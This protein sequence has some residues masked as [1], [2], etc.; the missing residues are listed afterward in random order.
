[1]MSATRRT[2]WIATVLAPLAWAVD[3]EASYAV[4][5]RACASP[6]LVH[7]IALWM[8]PLAAAAVSALGAVL[9]VRGWRRQ[10]AGAAETWPPDHFLAVCG[11][12]TSGFF[13]FVI[14]VQAIPTLVLRACDY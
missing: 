1:M 11:L 6:G 8:V 2:L 5:A 12:L 9:S 13:I 3:L 14:L 7:R 10:E 4:A